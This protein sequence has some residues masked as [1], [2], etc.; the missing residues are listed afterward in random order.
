MVEMTAGPI[1][2][3]ERGYEWSVCE[4]F[5]ELTRSEISFED[6]LKHEFI[7]RKEGIEGIA[8]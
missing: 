8:V 2:C 4:H 6:L 5:L 7:T 1:L 3:Q